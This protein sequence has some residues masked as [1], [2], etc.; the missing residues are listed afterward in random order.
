MR[1][2]SPLTH[3]TFVPSTMV[4]SSGRNPC[5]ISLLSG[6]KMTRFFTSESNCKL[7]VCAMSAAIRRG[8]PEVGVLDLTP[9]SFEVI[10]LDSSV[11]GEISTWALAGIWA[12]NIPRPDNKRAATARDIILFN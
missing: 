9:E 10:L 4:A 6:I 8:F 12:L 2:L 7:F 5:V 11:P 3:M 1:A